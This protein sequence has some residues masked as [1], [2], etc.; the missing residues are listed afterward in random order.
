MES[1]EVFECVCIC[2]H[3]ATG[4]AR[5]YMDVCGNTCPGNLAVLFIGDSGAAVLSSGKSSLA[6]R[7]ISAVAGEYIKANALG[8]LVVLQLTAT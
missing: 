8:I 3:T 2:F 4:V 5:R 7:S 6:S 1:G